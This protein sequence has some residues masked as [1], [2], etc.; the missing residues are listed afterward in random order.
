MSAHA[1]SSVV[2]IRPAQEL[3]GNPFSEVWNDSKEIEASSL[4]V[5]IRAMGHRAADD[6]NGG[7]RLGERFEEDTATMLLFARGAVILL[8][9]PVMRGQELMVINKRT[10]RYAHCCVTN[11]RA[12]PDVNYVEIEFTH[13]IPDFWGISFPRDAAG[14]VSAVAAFAGQISA[15]TQTNERA[16]G[17]V[18][19]PAKALAAAAC[20]GAANAGAVETAPALESA[21]TT[22]TS[23]PIP[24]EETDQ[25]P[26]PAPFFAL[27][28]MECVPVC[29]P[30]TDPL[31]GP[32]SEFVEAEA[33]PRLMSGEPLFTLAPRA[34]RRRLVATAVLGLCTM[35]LGYLFF[36]PPEEAASSDLESALPSPGDG[37][38][39]AGLAAVPAGTLNGE[40]ASSVVV[41]TAPEPEIETVDVPKQRVVLVGGMTMPAKGATKTADD[42]PELSANAGEEPAAGIPGKAE[43]LLGAARPAPPPPPQE[44]PPA[45]PEKPAP[46]LTPARLVT[47]VRPIYPPAAKQAQIQGNV[48]MEIQI[49]ASGNVTESKVLSG[50]QALRAAATAAVAKWKYEPALLGDRPTAS[51]SIVMVTFQLR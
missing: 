14:A 37:T 38:P 46:T 1:K 15:E 48:V 27:R 8:T 17:P 5:P 31:E 40:E 28:P 39:G 22:I 19:G 23:R 42:A 24:L 44:E 11:L 34:K 4:E 35:I 29:E 7:G 50:P 45:N 30:V 10:H 21:V 47:T 13:D 3:S 49:D 6:P 41:V 9:A 18:P 33:V 2:P 12:T 36:S 43:G 25:R 26:S 51:S 16:E 20:I 32:P